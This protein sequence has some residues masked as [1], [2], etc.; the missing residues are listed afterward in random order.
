MYKFVTPSIEEGPLGP[1]PL[2][3]R[4]RLNR[5]VSVFSMNGEWYE[6]RY[7]TEDEI[8]HSEHFYRGGYVYEIEDD[9]AA[10]LLALGY[11][12]SPI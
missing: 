5:G 11:D 2:F 7:P 12:V 10:E 1:G 6:M 9:I 4:Y 8:A 3:S